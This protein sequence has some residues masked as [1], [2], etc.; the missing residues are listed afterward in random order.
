GRYLSRADTTK[1]YLTDPEVM[2]LHERRLARRV[3]GEELVR[4]QFAR[5]PLRDAQRQAHL[6]VIAEPGAAPDDLLVPLLDAGQWQQFG[7]E[8]LQRAI[9]NSDLNTQLRDGNVSPFSPDMDTLQSFDLRARGFALTSSGF[10]PG[11]TLAE[12]AVNDETVAEL[13]VANSGALHAYLSRLSDNIGDDSQQYLF[14]SAPVAYVRRTLAITT[15]LCEKIGYFG[16]W[17]IGVGATG[18]K[19]VTSYLHYQRGM[20][21]GPVYDESDYIRSVE[22]TYVDIRDHPAQIANRLLGPLLRSL[23]VHGVFTGA[24]SDPAE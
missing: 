20:G 6:F 3:A 17:T 16:V 2:R 23:R 1:R 7:V 15:Y 5:D 11:R 22:T 4:R 18:L 12:N 8:L 24:L 14:D 10:G 19:G 9:H 21:H 13:E